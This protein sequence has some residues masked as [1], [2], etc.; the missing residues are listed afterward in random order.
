MLT[1]LPA[2]F[3]HEFD[4]INATVH[5]RQRGLPRP[6]AAALHR[7]RDMLSRHLHS[8]ILEVKLVLECSQLTMQTLENVKDQLRALTSNSDD[9]ASNDEDGDDESDGGDEDAS[10]GDEDAGDGDEDAGD[11]AE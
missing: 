10:D 2:E 6:D 7:T 5:A 8:D 3:Q 11:G 9:R 4:A 1:S